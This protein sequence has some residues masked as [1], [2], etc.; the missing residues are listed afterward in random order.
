M[1][2]ENFQESLN[3]SEVSFLP[4]DKMK[5]LDK[6]PRSELAAPGANHPL[7]EC[8][9]F[10]KSSNWGFHVKRPC[11]HLS[12]WFLAW[13]TS[14]IPSSSL[15]CSFLHPQTLNEHLLCAGHCCGSEAKAS[16]RRTEATASGSGSQWTGRHVQAFFG[17]SD[18]GSPRQA[19]APAVPCAWKALP[20]GWLLLPFPVSVQMAQP[21]RGLTHALL[22]LWLSCE[23]TPPSQELCSRP[24]LHPAMGSQGKDSCGGGL[25]R[26][27]CQPVFL[28]A[29]K[30]EMENTAFVQGPPRTHGCRGNQVC[31][32]VSFLLDSA[33]RE[34]PL[35]DGGP[36]SPQ[37]TDTN[38]RMRLQVG[39]LVSIDSSP[40]FPAV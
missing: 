7:D 23:C 13:L 3:G 30:A 4:I 22:I 28:K 9:Y 5:G 26:E 40:S 14:Q 8:I 36:G 11:R 34:P 38:R 29:P 32:D 21:P 19:L 6:R 31:R 33:P 10:L 35:G 37:D 27:I 2:H 25:Y 20:A 18:A 1:S 17:F 15:L 24:L 12:S 39:A 16:L